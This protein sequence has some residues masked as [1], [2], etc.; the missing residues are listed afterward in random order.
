M[1]GRYRRLFAPVAGFYVIGALKDSELLFLSYG[2]LEK[3]YLDIPKLERS[4]RILT[5]NGFAFYQRR[6]NAALSQTAEERY[7][8]LRKQ[9]P[10]LE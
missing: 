2:A 10:G 8:A 9:Y 5:R 6:I 4:F 3:L 7:F 1:G